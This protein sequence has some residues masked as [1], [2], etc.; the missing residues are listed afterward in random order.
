[1]SSTIPTRATSEPSIAAAAPSSIRGSSAAPVTSDRIGLHALVSPEGGSVGTIDFELAGDGTISVAIAIAEKAVPHPWG[2]YDQDSCGMPVANHDAPFQFADVEDGRRTEQIDARSYLAFPG[3]LVA[4]I[5]STSGA[6]PYGCADLGFGEGVIA[7]PSPTA[8]CAPKLPGETPV[9]GED[10]AFARDYRS[11]SE[12]YL[13]RVDG[14]DVR[15]L[16]FSLG[17]DMKP[18]WS[19]D[20]QQ[21]AFR[22]QRDGNDE[23]YVM[24]AD[25]SCQRNLTNSSPDDRSPAWSPDGR[26]IAFDHFFTDTIQDI[27]LIEVDDAQ[28]RRVTKRS[29]EYPSWSPDGGQLAFASARTGHYEVYVINRDGTNERRLTHDGAYDMYPAWSPDGTSIAYEHGVNGFDSGME[30][31]VMAV[32]GSNVR[33]VTSNNVS[34]RF[35]AWSLDGGLAWSESG[36]IM[37]AATPTSSAKPIGIGQFPAFRP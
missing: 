20:G 34:D 12:I 18:S 3:K 23:I 30:I 32:D 21:I 26:T 37:V 27:A 36:T 31:Q 4:L 24:N 8:P 13:M 5:V 25:G 19:P 6:A 16:T 33:P 11:D 15:R 14:T 29:G 10:I 9:G 22:T 17:L 1:M 28:V 35:P 2:I 7:S